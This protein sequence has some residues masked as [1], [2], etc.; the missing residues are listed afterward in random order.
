MTQITNVID[1][2]IVATLNTVNNVIPK[3]EAKLEHLNKED[4]FV[5]LKNAGLKYSE[6]RL[7]GLTI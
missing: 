5:H 6:K 1:I 4:F 7:A 2:M 3:M